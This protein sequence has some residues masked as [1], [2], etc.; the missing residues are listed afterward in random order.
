[1]WKKVWDVDAENRKMSKQRGKGAD[2]KSNGASGSGNGSFPALGNPLSPP[3]PTIPTAEL[4]GTS[5]W[6]QRIAWQ[7]IKEQAAREAAPAPTM[8]SL[9]K[10]G[11]AAVRQPKGAGDGSGYGSR[12]I[13]ENSKGGG[14]DDKGGKGK[15]K[16]KS[17]TKGRKGDGKGADA[18]NDETFG[19]GV[20]DWHDAGNLF[21]TAGRGDIP[22]LKKKFP[23][24]I[25]G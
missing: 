5:V 10:A 7:Q 6:E 16:G 23:K 11:S 4:A 1:L 14:K 24:K 9:P 22:M 25:F 20:P 21:E 12:Q 2:A 17:G 3:K 15:S 19:G 18:L 8:T 13:S